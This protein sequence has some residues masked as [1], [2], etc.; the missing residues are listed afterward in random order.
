MHYD[1][2]IDVSKARLDALLWDAQHGKHRRKSV[3]NTEAGVAQL[4]AW[5]ATLEITAAQLRAT[6]EPTST[7]HECAAYALHAAGCTV[8]LVNCLRLRRYAQSL[9][10]L[11]KT[12]ALDAHLLARY[13][14]AE[15]PAAWTPPEPSA[16]A[17]RALL[18]HRDAL[19]VDIQR[20]RNRTE[21]ASSRTPDCVR[22]SMAQ[23]LAFLQAQ[24]KVANS[25]IASHIKR[26]APLRH[27]SKLLQSIPGVG[28]RVSEHL[29]ALL[30]THRFGSAEQLSAY[31][32]LVP[33]DW[34]SGSSIHRRARLSKAGPSRLRQVLYL[35][36]VVAA[37]YNPHIKAQ[38]TRLLAKG[39]SKMAAI[40]AAMHKLAQLCFGVVHTNTPYS[41]TWRTQASTTA[42]TKT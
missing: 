37:R 7:Y 34:Q 42:A 12:D 28:P 10:L 16:Q 1:L 20:E 39:K 22:Q 19:K 2:G 15:Q 27:V 25:A 24:L 23:L 14:A 4:L 9:G 13:G 40:G 31:L 36:A 11:S 21:S 38:Y 6:L 26:H 29:C 30:M 33:V 41:A 3:P 32:G 35:P 5:L 8:C 18:A 17:L